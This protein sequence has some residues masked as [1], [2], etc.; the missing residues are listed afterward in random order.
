[1]FTMLR[2]YRE[3]LRPLH[4]HAHKKQE[5]DSYGPHGQTPEKKRGNGRARGGSCGAPQGNS[6]RS[7]FSPPTKGTCSPYFAAALLT[8]R[9]RGSVEKAQPCPVVNDARVQLLTMAWSVA[10]MGGA[11]RGSA[12]RGERLFSTHLSNVGA[13][14]STDPGRNHPDRQNLPEDVRSQV[15][16]LMDDAPTPSQPSSSGHFTSHLVHAA[17]R[18]EAH[19]PLWKKAGNARICTDRRE[20]VESLRSP[21]PE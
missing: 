20:T 6:S 1:M 9:V 2:P 7:G 11:S 3:Q 5:T 21:S 18:L 19:V 4:P 17:K 10:R 14:V 8:S 16:R 13:R 12:R 15:Q